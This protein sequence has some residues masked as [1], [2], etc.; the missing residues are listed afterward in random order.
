MIAANLTPVLILCA[1]FATRMGELAPGVP[2][3]LLPLAGRPLLDHVLDQL[4]GLSELG[5]SHLVVNRRSFD[6][7]ERW[8]GEHH[9]LGSR[10]HLWDNG[11]EHPDR[12]PGAN[13]DLRFLWKRAGRPEK[14]LVAGGDN[15]FLFSLRPFWTSFL[16]G[17][18]TLVLAL[19]E[20]DLQER[21]RSGV[22]ELDSDG[23]A[24]ALVEKPERPRSS[25]VCPAIYA[26]QRSA[27]RRLEEY[28]DG[29]Q[30]T[31]GLGNFISFLIERERVRAFRVEGRRLHIG[32]PESYRAAERA[33]AGTR[34]PAG[35][36]KRSPDQDS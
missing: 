28:L 36:E 34:S 12:R 22:L 27:F 20:P 11:C 25:W 13:A 17:A 35:Y 24:R 21:R 30:P 1:G 10:L 18:E 31:D 3:P 6:R 29:G 14:A 7:F 33:L 2:K 8:V 9:A 26:C 15:L 5:E 23:F 19:R 32:S 4:A 16:Q